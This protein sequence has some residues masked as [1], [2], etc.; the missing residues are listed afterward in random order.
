M[1]Y[2]APPRELTV[3][4]EEVTPEKAKEMLGRNTINRHL[5]KPD[6]LRLTG[7][8]DRGEFMYDAT[9]AIAVTATG[10]LVNGQGRLTAIANGDSTVHVLVMRGVRPEVIKVID[11]GRTRN[12]AQYLQIHG[13][14]NKPTVVAAAVQWL[15][16]MNHG[17]EIIQPRA[18]VPSIDQLLELLAEHPQIVQSIQAGYEA[19]A[20]NKLPP[21]AMLVAYHYCF[22]SVNS[23]LADDFYR[24]LATGVDLSEG[25]PQHALREKYRK[26]SNKE[27]SRRVRG[28]VLGAWLVKAWNAEVA[29]E[30]LT[31]KQLTWTTSGRKAEAF[32]KVD[33]LPWEVSDDAFVTE[34]DFVEAGTDDGLFDA[35]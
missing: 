30:S 15:Y 26:E 19:Y 25:S 22:A 29:G 16:R 24:G 17:M 34:D 28:H 33:G 13:Y 3:S 1:Q 35:P 6:V 14:N 20:S 18:L 7:I 32:P 8:I 21:E 23:E 9:D 12:F 5:S 10:D 11:Q 27:P 31:E 2:T 4:V